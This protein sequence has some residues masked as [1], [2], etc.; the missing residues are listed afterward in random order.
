MI[1]AP[2]CVQIMSSQSPE[3]AANIL[4]AEFD[5]DGLAEAVR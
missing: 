2:G 4:A 1:R 5:D 3:L